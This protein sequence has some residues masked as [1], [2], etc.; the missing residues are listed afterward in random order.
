MAVQPIR[1][2]HPL[3]GRLQYHL[4]SG[5]RSP[6]QGKNILAQLWTNH[7]WGRL[8]I[9]YTWITMRANRS[10]TDLGPSTLVRTRPRDC[11]VLGDGVGGRGTGHEL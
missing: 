10:T 7:L 8:A 5:L 4:G 9:L 1:F 11:D 3:D 2:P 6:S